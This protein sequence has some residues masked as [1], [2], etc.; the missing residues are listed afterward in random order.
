MERKKLWIKAAL[1]V[2]IA[3]ILAVGAYFVGYRRAAAGY[4][5]EKERN[6]ILNRA[7]LK[8]FGEA[9]GT[10]WVTGH[11]NPD[12]DTVCSAMAYAHLLNALGYD[13]QAAVLG[14]IDHES[15]YVLQLAGL[16]C[17]PV[18][19]NAAGKN[20]VLVDHSE[21]LQSANELEQANVL[22]IIDHHGIGTVTTAGPILFDAR[23][24]GATATIIWIRYQNYGVEVDRQT[25]ML[26]L[27]AL[28]SDTGNL[29]PGST[30][31]ADREAYAELSRLAGVTDTETLYHNMFK[32]LISYGDMTDEEIFFSDYKE[33]EVGGKCY[34]IGI[35]NVYDEEEAKAMAA[36]MKPVLPDAAAARGMDMVYAQV[37]VYHDGIS[38]TYLVPSDETASAVAAAAFENAVFDGTS[39]VMIPGA[40][41][42][43]VIV[44]GISGVL[45]AKD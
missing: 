20:V 17:P 38:I 16:E 30:T 23:P 21:Y 43:A 7:D 34:G 14:V 45:G 26:L 2:L 15:E 37:T 33:Y 6:V 18:L 8:G 39:Y 35:V 13:A 32:A 36:R 24:L 3:A 40:S 41:R 4:E 12:T 27:G 44:P 5:A 19:E 10:I 31:D 11:K 25:A 29:Y 22:G 28:I 1:C 9:E 42:K